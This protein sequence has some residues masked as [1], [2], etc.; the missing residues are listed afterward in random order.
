MIPAYSA[1]C[2]ARTEREVAEA[3]FRLITHHAATIIAEGMRAD[4]ERRHVYLCELGARLRGEVEVLSTRQRRVTVRL[5]YY[6]RPDLIAASRT[7]DPA[8]QGFGSER[9]SAGCQRSAGRASNA[10]RSATAIEVIRADRTLSELHDAETAPENRAPGPY[11]TARL[12]HT[13]GEQVQRK[14]LYCRDCGRKKYAGD[15]HVL[16]ERCREKARLYRQWKRQQTQ[17][18]SADGQ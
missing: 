17:A 8:V 4:P 1:I 14:S 15:R 11:M 10:L 18:G 5:V 13:L 9:A 16:C 3:A 12:M 7:E 2:A 6:R